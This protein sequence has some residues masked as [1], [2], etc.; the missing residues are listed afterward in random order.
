M[1][2]VPNTKWPPRFKMALKSFWVQ[3]LPKHAEKCC[4][5]V[6]KPKIDGKNG[7]QD[8]KWPPKF[9]MAAQN[10]FSRNLTKLREK[11]IKVQK[12]DFWV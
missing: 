7:R 1:V 9:K 4:K 11:L 6:Q 10:F 12:N 5:K 3:N 2:A 8:S